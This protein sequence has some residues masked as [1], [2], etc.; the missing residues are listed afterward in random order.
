MGLRRDLQAHVHPA[1]CIGLHA[2]ARAHVPG[3]ST[4]HGQADLI[5]QH[6]IGVGTVT[7]QGAN[8]ALA[9]PVAGVDVPV[10]A[11]DVQAAGGVGFAI[12]QTQAGCAIED[13]EASPQLAVEI[14]V[15]VFQASPKRRGTRRIVRQQ[16]GAKIHARRAR[17][18]DDQ[19][20]VQRVD[21]PVSRSQAGAGHEQRVALEVRLGVQDGSTVLECVHAE[22]VGESAAEPEQRECL[23][24]DHHAAG[25]QGHIHARGEVVLALVVAQNELG[26][27]RCAAEHAQVHG[28]RE[29]VAG[30]GGRAAAGRT[31]LVS[32]I[33]LGIQGGRTHGEGDIH[34]EWAHGHVRGG[35]AAGGS[36]VA[37]A[38]VHGDRSARDDGVLG[39]P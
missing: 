37:Q 17:A 32:R 15:A 13:A 25:A 23:G 36:A 39:E 7:Q 1:L 26:L 19:L 27:D 28:S 2:H 3:A 38:K 22:V 34:A 8:D 14:A 30:Q 29:S 16:P 33:D 10:A 11:A 12:A 20:A 35:V 9:I 6:Q 4:A 24:H 21:E 18:S 31:R 5:A